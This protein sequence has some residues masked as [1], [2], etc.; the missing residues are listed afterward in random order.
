ML[1]LETRIIGKLSSEKSRRERSRSR[2]KRDIWYVKIR[3]T[4]I[5]WRYSLFMLYTFL[6]SGSRTVLAS[7]IIIPYRFSTAND[8]LAIHHSSSI[9]RE[10]WKFFDDSPLFLFLCPLLNRTSSV[11]SSIS[12]CKPCYTRGFYVIIS[13]FRAPDRLPFL[14][15][16]AKPI[17]L[18]SIQ[19]LTLPF[20]MLLFFIFFVCLL[21]LFC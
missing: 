16:L 20:C 3:D 18:I 5:S 15:Y 2:S 21:L 4:H 14:C 12:P 1:H 11:V 13:D 6:Y 7:C 17:L 19:K 10:N 8:D 9:W